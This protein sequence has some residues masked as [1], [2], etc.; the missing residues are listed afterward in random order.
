MSPEMLVLTV[1]LAVLVLALVVV[2]I[3]VVRAPRTD[4]LAMLKM[5]TTT[6]GPAALVTAGLALSVLWK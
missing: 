6:Y 3:V 1:A 4:L 2:A 5:I